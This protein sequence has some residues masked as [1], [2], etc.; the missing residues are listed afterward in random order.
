MVAQPEPSGTRT[1]RA[2]GRINVI[3][4]HTD[5]QDGLCLPMAID[6]ECR[7]VVAP[8]THPETVTATSAQMPGAVAVPTAGTTEPASVLPA[9]GRFVAGAVSAC[10][11][12]G[13][14]V[15]ACGLTVTSTV[16]AG[17][18]LSSSSALSVALVVAFTDLAGVTLDRVDLARLALDAEVR[19]TGVPG[20]LLDQMAALHG[21]A[22]H[23]LLLDCRALTA[24]PVA[25]PRALG[26]VVVHSGRPRTLAGSA[27]A[28]R[29]AEVE[30]VA[31]RL[32]LA[33][34]RDAAPEQVA[35]DP[36]A[37]HVV[38]EN[39]RV[40]AFADALRAGRT[41]ALGPLM[42]ASHASLR[43]DYGV[44]TPELDRAVD[45]LMAHGALGARL[46]GAGFGGCAVGLVQRN[47][48]D[49]VVAKVARALEAA[50]EPAPVAF[51]VRGADA[52]GE[53]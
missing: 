17:S 34:L 45:L 50:G 47:H 20:G 19:A 36:R 38:T 21:V 25:L 13:V 11:D 29:R 46:T 7:V 14:A 23:L 22:D 27:Y 44:S 30:A 24:E 49:D 8:P 16:P 12:R 31:R 4:D 5:Y 37:R 41:D 40:R 48:A 33:T 15:P 3:G 35:D 32:G 28:Q 42:V 6:R 39:A 2:P 52:A 51:A 9:W 10:I 18:G 43:D 53:V 26:F 1:W